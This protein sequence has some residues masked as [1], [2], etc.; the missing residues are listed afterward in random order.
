MKKLKDGVS[1]GEC[2]ARTMGGGE[3]YWHPVAH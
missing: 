2:V 3:S 1:N